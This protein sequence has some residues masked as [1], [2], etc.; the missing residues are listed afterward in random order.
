M[1]VHEGYGR[2]SIWRRIVN[3]EPIVELRRFIIVKLVRLLL[4]IIKATL[5]Y[6][7]F[8]PWGSEG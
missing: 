2:R 3:L 7:T 5:L 1:A 6:F 8:L 4:V